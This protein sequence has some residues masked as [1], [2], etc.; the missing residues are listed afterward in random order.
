MTRTPTNIDVKNDVVQLYRIINSKL[1]YIEFDVN[2]KCR[3]V[4]TY[5]NMPD[6]TFLKYC[7]T[8]REF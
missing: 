8:L 4:A 2:A 1:H 5:F 7:I 3:D 6:E